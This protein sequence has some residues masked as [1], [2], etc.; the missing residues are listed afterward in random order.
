[1]ILLVYAV[2][3]LACVYTRLVP[4]Q[5]G[6]V[7]NYE[8]SLH[9]GYGSWSDFI[10]LMVIPYLPGGPAYAIKRT[11]SNPV[12]VVVERW[13]RLSDAECVYFFEEDR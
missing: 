12:E 11:M 7:G 10:P 6:R 5:E 1:M 4:V 2:Q 8:V 9:R 3:L 13:E